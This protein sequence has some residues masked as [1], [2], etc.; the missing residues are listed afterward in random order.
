MRWIIPRR[1]LDCHLYKHVF[2]LLH[3][4][5]KKIDKIYLCVYFEHMYACVLPR[6]EYDQGLLSEQSG[7]WVVR[8]VTTKKKAEKVLCFTNKLFVTDMSEAE[9]MHT[10][11]HTTTNVCVKVPMHPVLVS[12]LCREVWSLPHYLWHYFYSTLRILKWWWSVCLEFW[13]PNRKFFPSFRN[14]NG[15]MVCLQ[16][17]KQNSVTQATSLHTT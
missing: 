7:T 10:H 13:R 1:R 12:D 8:P 4:V 5:L 6:A 14:G 3:L 17:A 2:L 15:E 11:T 16:K 9:P